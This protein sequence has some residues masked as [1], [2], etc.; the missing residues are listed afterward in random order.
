[1]TALTDSTVFTE[2]MASPA[3][4]V[5]A[6]TPDECFETTQAMWTNHCLEAGDATFPPGLV[7][8]DT[9]IVVQKGGNQYVDSYSAFMD[10]T[11]KL[12]TP[13]DDTLQSNGI[14]TIYVV[15]IATDYCVYYSTID[16]L[17]LGYDVYVVLDATRGIAP[18][19]VNA[20]VA[21]MTA[22][23]ATL[24]NTTDVLSLSCPTSS[25]TSPPSAA[26]PAIWTINMLAM[27]VVTMGSVG[28][29][30]M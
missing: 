19:T 22:Q 29:V 4:S 2:T 14:T 28:L 23:G 12:K 8:A 9:D 3:C 10:N 1:V 11:K 5:C 16:A 27:G 13:L 18:D 20:A 17:T 24:I 25:P 21:D 15:G 6:D 7:T 30:G 26:A